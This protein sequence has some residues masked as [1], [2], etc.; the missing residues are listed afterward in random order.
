MLRRT[1]AGKEGFNETARGCVTE[2]EAEGGF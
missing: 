2:G 1:A